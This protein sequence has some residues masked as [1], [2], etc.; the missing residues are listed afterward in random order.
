M[1]LLLPLL[2]FLGSCLKS[3]PVYTHEGEAALQA[4][5]QWSDG[6]AE[7]T[8]PAR[9]R[10]V[11]EMEMEADSEQEEGE[12]EMGFAVDVEILSQVELQ[13]RGR[14]T[15]EGEGLE[16]GHVV[17]FRLSVGEEGLRATILDTRETRRWISADSPLGVQLSADRVERALKLIDQ[18]GEVLQ[19]LEAPGEGSPPG[20]P[21]LMP[22]KLHSSQDL[23]PV[24]H[25]MA[26]ARYA[27]PELATISY[28]YGEEDSRVFFRTIDTTTSAEVVQTFHRS[29]GWLEKITIEVDHEQEDG[30]FQLEMS[31]DLTPLEEGLPE[32]QFA[33]PE[34]VL[35][36]D[37]QFDVF[38]P[39]I[40]GF[41]FA[42][43]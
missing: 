30:A 25:P 7:P 34:R 6:L 17:P 13:V 11:M 2:V 12:F 15:L 3:E 37:A 40:E 35:D 8:Y 39:L 32:F 27:W 33:D 36:L 24:I 18:L 43:E 4:M 29:S 31:M 21:P 38:W 20:F 42:E 41:Q 26:A 23:G 16:A 1:R 28:S 5:R 19:H 22:P 14:L 9:F 10:V